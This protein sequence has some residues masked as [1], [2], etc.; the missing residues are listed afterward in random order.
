MVSGTPILDIKPYIAYTDSYPEAASGAFQVR[1]EMKPVNW[2]T[3]I[4]MDGDTK[5]L[6]EKVIGLDPRSGLDQT[7]VFGVSIA[8]YN[9][10]FRFVMDH[11]EILEVAK[12]RP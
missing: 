7:E 6:I 2:M 5:V 4:N 11:F 12:E 3:E 1:P 8:G 10:R 9:I